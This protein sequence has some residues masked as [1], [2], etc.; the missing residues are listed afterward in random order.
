MYKLK[1]KENDH[2]VIE[3]IENIENPKKREDAYQL[4]DIF[5]ETTGY[6]AKMWGTSI[7]GFGSYHYKYKSGHEGDAPF[8]GFSPRKAKISLYLATGEPKREE[9]LNQLGKHTT[10]KACV[11]VNK[12]SDIDVTILKLL[13]DQSVNFLKVTYPN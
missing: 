7:I 3:F 1:T 2:S 5:T 13:I 12:L 11:Y 8:V 9:L 4:L 10:G 6:P